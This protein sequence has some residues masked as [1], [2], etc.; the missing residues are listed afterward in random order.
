[1]SAKIKQKKC[2]AKDC[3]NMF[4]QFSSTQIACSVRCA[5]NLVLEK[6]A[7][8]YK[9]ETR[10]MKRE[11]NENNRAHQLKLT[12]ATFNSFIRLR[13][14]GKPCISC[15]TTKPVQFCAGHY[16]TV[17]GNPELRF[18][19]INVH[20]Q[21]NKNCNLSLSGNIIEYRK[22]LLKRIGPDKLD[23]L[24]GPHEAKKYTL[25]DIKAIRADYKIKIKN[26]DSLQWS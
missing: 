16:K 18:N 5:L 11:H 10:S 3:G 6:K 19:E 21:C 17:G 14:T 23:W 15:G 22:G 2:K 4:N 7:K 25:D 1:M 24:E 9:A 8:A 20:G 13:D 26:F 12:Q